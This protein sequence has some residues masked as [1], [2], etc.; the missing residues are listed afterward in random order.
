MTAGA[1]RVRVLLGCCH[2]IHFRSRKALCISLFIPNSAAY[3]YI[4]IVINV[5]IIFFINLGHIL[6]Y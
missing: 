6:R 3:I 4:Y 5:A 1:N 2:H